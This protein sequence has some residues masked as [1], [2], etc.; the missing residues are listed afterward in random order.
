M[1]SWGEAYLAGSYLGIDLFL[2]WTHEEMGDFTC[3]LFNSSRD[4]GLYPTEKYKAGKDDFYANEIDLTEDGFLMIYDMENN[5]VIW[6]VNRTEREMFFDIFINPTRECVAPNTM[7]WIWDKHATN[8]FMVW[9]DYVC[10]VKEDDDGE[11]YVE[12][13]TTTAKYSFTAIDWDFN[14]LIFTDNINF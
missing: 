11:L 5:Q 4:S 9:I 3:A 12:K 14:G 8:K 1:D 10:K 2:Y 13:L 7:H 6:W